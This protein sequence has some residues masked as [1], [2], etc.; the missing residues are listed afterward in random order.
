MEVWALPSWYPNLSHYVN[1]K[2]RLLGWDVKPSSNFRSKWN[3]P[4]SFD[5][6]C[7]KSDFRGL[8][9][10]FFFHLK[11]RISKLRLQMEDTIIGGIGGPGH[12]SSGS[13][14]NA[15][16]WIRTPL[17]QQHSSKNVSN[18][19]KQYSMK[20]TVLQRCCRPFHH[21]YLA[22]RSEHM[23][24]PTFTELNAPILVKVWTWLLP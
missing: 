8:S 16:A 19:I 14:K 1:L 18:T 20:Y 13:D 12:P 23:S 10:Y 22:F 11:F 21:S 17:R 24:P 9:S 5:L 2:R 15:E 6:P 3:T 7:E 4:K